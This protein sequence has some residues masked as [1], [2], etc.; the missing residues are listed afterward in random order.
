MESK[1]FMKVVILA[2][3]FGKR[4]GNLTK[5]ISKHMLPI[6]GKPILEW[7]IEF[8]KGQLKIDE[9]IINLLN[10]VIGVNYFH[11]IT[12]LLGIFMK[13]IFTLQH[14]EFNYLFDSL[15]GLCLEY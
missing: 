12:L 14:S 8:I 5:T 3:G 6:A 9:I 7:N 15:D 1:E 11:E 10:I 4:M 2:G 13:F